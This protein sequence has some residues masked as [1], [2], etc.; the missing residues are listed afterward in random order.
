MIIDM[1]HIVNITC[2]TLLS[3]YFVVHEAEFFT[4]LF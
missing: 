3:E 2:L 4:V 1:T